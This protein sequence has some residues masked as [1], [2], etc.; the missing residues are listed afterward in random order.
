M[1]IIMNLIHRQTKLYKT[2]KEN[3][4]EWSQ[5]IDEI[6]FRKVLKSLLWEMKKE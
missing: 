3:A 4:N 5:D 2:F 1:Q 6:H